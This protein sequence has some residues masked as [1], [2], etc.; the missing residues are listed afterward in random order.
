MSHV[1]AVCLCT[2][3]LVVHGDTGGV[4]VTASSCRPDNM[5]AALWL[6]VCGG[7][8]GASGG[9]DLKGCNGHCPDEAHLSG[10]R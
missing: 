3:A 2:G 7:G 8:G 10:H 4:E 5:A 6:A 9:D 1:E